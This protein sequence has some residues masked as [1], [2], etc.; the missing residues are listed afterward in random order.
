MSQRSGP[1]RL[2]NLREGISGVNAASARSVV[3]Q[4]AQNGAEARARL[5][6]TTTPVAK[7]RALLSLGLTLGWPMNW[8]GRWT[9]ALA[10]AN[11]NGSSRGHDGWRERC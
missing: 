2:T 7:N 6:K 5:E 3:V 9:E 4:E 1:G 8:A 10:R 11:A